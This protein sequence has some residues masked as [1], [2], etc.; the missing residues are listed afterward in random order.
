M[1]KAWQAIIDQN[2]DYGVIFED[3]LRYFADNF[4]GLLHR[5]VFQVDDPLAQARHGI[6]HLQ[7]CGDNAL[8]PRGSSR[9]PRRQAT[10]KEVLNGDEVTPCTAAYVVSNRATHQLIQ[11]A[12]PVK[13][14]LDRAFVPSVIGDLPR[15][16]FEPAIAQVGPEWLMSDVQDMSKQLNGRADFGDRAESDA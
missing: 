9:Q 1:G 5:E 3:D 4:E 16:R 13:H 15:F 8:W 12:F 10:L 14:Q 11:T 2:L 7:H 6:I